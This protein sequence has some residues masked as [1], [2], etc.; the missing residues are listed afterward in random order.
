MQ[1]V[2][3]D[4]TMQ[5][6]GSTILEEFQ[7]PTP[8]DKSNTLWEELVDRESMSQYAQQKLIEMS[9]D[10]DALS[11]AVADLRAT[12]EG[13]RGSRGDRELDV[14]FLRKTALFLSDAN[15]LLRGFYIFAGLFSGSKM[16]IEGNVATMF[17]DILM[18]QY[19]V[20]SLNK[21]LMIMPWLEKRNHRD[22]EQI[23]LLMSSIKE[24]ASK[25]L[26]HVNTVL[27]GGKE[28][29][30]KHVKSAWEAAESR[31]KAALDQMSETKSKS[32]P[33]SV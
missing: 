7:R 1:E 12:A 28:M 14:R 5:R 3:D 16:Q 4:G 31:L 24:V 22:A 13:K 19:F 6:N 21:V 33:L 2:F 10:S 9:K 17:A 8:S 26:A 32:I 18:L 15:A 11:R 27:L 25:A 30:T 20:D 23:S 29:S